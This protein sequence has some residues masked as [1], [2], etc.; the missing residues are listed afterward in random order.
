MRRRCA[1][2]MQLAEGAASLSMRGVSFY[3]LGMLVLPLIATLC[4]V[5]V[6]TRC[7]SLQCAHEAS[8]QRLREYGWLQV[9]S[10]RSLFI[11]VELSSHVSRRSLLHSASCVNRLSPFRLVSGPQSCSLFVSLFHQ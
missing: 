7:D 11:A 10:F 4:A 3:A 5:L 2:A 9:S 1:I 6:L 8:R